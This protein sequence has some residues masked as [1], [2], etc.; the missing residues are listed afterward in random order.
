MAK[1]E[2]QFPK[3]SRVAFSALHQERERLLKDPAPVAPGQDMAYVIRKY[4]AGPKY[5]A[6]WPRGTRDDYD[7]RLDYLRES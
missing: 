3:V 2:T 4:I 1:L 7:K 5:I 6:S